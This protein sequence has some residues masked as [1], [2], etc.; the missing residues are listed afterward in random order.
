MNTEKPTLVILAAAMGSRYGSLKQMDSCTPE[1]D[2][3]I[4]F[5]FTMRFK[6][7]LEKWFLSLGKVLK[8]CLKLFLIK[9]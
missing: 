6:L 9:N 3:I 8:R 7:V 4:D 1:G 2:T 5:L